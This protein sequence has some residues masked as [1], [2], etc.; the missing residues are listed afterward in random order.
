M[1]FFDYVQ[2]IEN[3]AVRRTSCSM[4][5]ALCVPCAVKRYALAFRSPAFLTRPARM[6]VT[7]KRS[8]RRTP[9]LQLAGKGTGNGKGK[10]LF[11]A[12]RTTKREFS[13]QDAKAPR[14]L[15]VT[16]NVSGQMIAC[17]R[18]LEFA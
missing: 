5:A 2:D 7:R 14:I 10:G 8:M 11:S 4:T 6:L 12:Q 9:G 17:L 16:A 13:R 3:H 18:D 15:G 1:Y